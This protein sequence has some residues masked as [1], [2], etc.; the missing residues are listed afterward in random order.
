MLF[1]AECRNSAVQWLRA[2]QYEEP[3]HE[4]NHSVDIEHG[5][6][7]FLLR[8]ALSYLVKPHNSLFRLFG[9]SGNTH[10]AYSSIV[11]R[12]TLALP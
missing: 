6:N 3:Q 4:Q 10:R 12:S 5:D 7:L 1:I 11:M 9:L 8:S 2:N